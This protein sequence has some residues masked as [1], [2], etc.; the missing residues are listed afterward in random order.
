MYIVVETDDVMN[1][2]PVTMSPRPPHGGRTKIAN[3]PAIRD[4]PMPQAI[5]DLREIRGGTIPNQNDKNENT[6]KV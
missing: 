4:A 3:N 6:K 1:A 2:C 5:T